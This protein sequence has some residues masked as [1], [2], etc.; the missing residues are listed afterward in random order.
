MFNI[1]KKKKNVFHFF[2]SSIFTVDTEKRNACWVSQIPYIH[3]NSYI[4]I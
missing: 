1:E 3:D 2:F 4:Y